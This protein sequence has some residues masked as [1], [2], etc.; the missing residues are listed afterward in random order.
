MKPNTTV[1]ARAI[2]ELAHETYRKQ[3]DAEK[4]RILARRAQSWWRRV[5]PFTITI[6]WRKP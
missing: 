1:R 4:A 2:E 6:T 5:L 3:V